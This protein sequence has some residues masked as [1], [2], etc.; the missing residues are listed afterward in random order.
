MKTVC[1]VLN[2]L[3]IK[4]Q[5]TNDMIAQEASHFHVLL[6]IRTRM[7]MR[8]HTTAC[9]ERLWST[10]SERCCEGEPSVTGPQ[11]HA[12]RTSRP[13]VSAAF[14]FPLSACYH[15]RRCCFG[16]SDC[17]PLSLLHRL[18]GHWE[19]VWL[20][21]LKNK[22]GGNSELKAGRFD[23]LSSLVSGTAVHRGKEPGRG[24]EHEDF[25]LSCSF[26]FSFCFSV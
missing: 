7:Q 4:E 19:C 16:S 13:H 9:G 14:G 24:S 23:W 20:F 3:E 1:R 21:K 8:T 11:S 17:L 5:E 22:S 6:V 10:L 2:V 12:V 25:F 18:S 26:F 15:V